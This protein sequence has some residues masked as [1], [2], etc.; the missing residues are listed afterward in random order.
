MV[1][2]YFYLNAFAYAYACEYVVKLF[3][4]M[5]KCTHTPNTQCQMRS[6]HRHHRIFDIIAE[7]NINN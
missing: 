6:K 1:F 5:E 3:G 4:Q 2:K 7:I